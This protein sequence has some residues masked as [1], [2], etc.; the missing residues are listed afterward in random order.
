MDISHISYSGCKEYSNSPGMYVD[1]VDAKNIFDFIT[2]EDHLRLT[3]YLKSL[4]QPLDIMSMKDHR[5]FTLL[6]YAAYK[7]I[8]NCFKIIYE[9]ATKFNI[10]QK[11]PIDK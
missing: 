9:Y 10:N 8:T 3:L 5:K 1:G 4:E 6:T 7:N 2:N 11:T